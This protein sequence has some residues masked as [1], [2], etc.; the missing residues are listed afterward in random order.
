MP[1][2]QVY[3]KHRQRGPLLKKRESLVY[4]FQI[5][6][7]LFFMSGLLLV[8]VYVKTGEI[9]IIY[10]VLLITALLL[11][12]TIYSL[13]GVYRRS[14]SLAQGCYQLSVAWSIF[15]LLLLFIGFVTK[16]SEDF[17][18][19]VFLLWAVIGFVVQIIV[20]SIMYRAIGVFR[21][22]FVERTECLIVGR[23]RLA[24]HL[25][26]SIN[27]NKWLPDQ[28]V[29]FVSYED[30][31]CGDGERR[32]FGASPV[33]GSL[34]NIKNIIRENFIKRVYIAVPLA[35]S[36]S[37]EGIHIELLDMNV[38]LIWV[39]DIYALKL[40]NH[41]I[42]EVAGLPLIFLN[43]SPITSTRTGIFLKALMDRIVA[44]FLLLLLSPLFLMI[45]LFIKYGSRGPV[46]FKQDRHGWDGAVFKIWKFRTMYL[47]DEEKGTVK[48]ATKGDA[49]VTEI[50]AFL[51]KT[52]IDELPQLINV[53]LGEMSLVGPRPHAVVHNNYYDEHI[54]AYLLRHRIKPGITGLA[55]INGCR[56]ETETM[57]KMRDRVAY[58]VDYI[59]NWS[60]W[61]DIKILVNTPFTL[62]SKDIY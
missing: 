41:S 13:S 23:G 54:E 56:G 38:D 58:D 51:R 50:G 22:H 6:V 18:R 61:L 25:K 9:P 43:E 10:R 37:V 33:L 15:L 14:G 3:T 60:L 11:Q 39:P 35:Q 34:K 45:A 42:R 24:E 47:H 52:S 31:F 5:L 7:D 48:Q 62:L 17:S 53:L 46:F 59:N 2:S 29:G 49:R 28:I 30:N 44:V 27:N 20:Y 4:T 12:F 21:D 40:L 19:E 8:L 26:K 16:V 36:A 32:K 57:E 1:N 55:Q